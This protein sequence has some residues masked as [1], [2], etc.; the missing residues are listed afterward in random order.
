[1]L[2]ARLVGPSGEVVAVERD[3]NSIAK[4][5]ARVTEAGFHNVNFSESNVSEITDEKPF[6]A[7]GRPLYSDVSSRSGCGVAIN[8]TIGATGRS[9][10]FS[11]ANVG[12][13]HCAFGGATS[14][15]RN[16]L[17]H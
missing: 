7:V 2:V 8:F 15:V 14:L 3:R 12:P 4:A 11:G 9:V 13:G 17:S 5:S 6:D 1:M 10:C 16:G